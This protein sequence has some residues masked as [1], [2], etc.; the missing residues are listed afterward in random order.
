MKTEDIVIL[1]TKVNKKLCGCY[2][3]QTARRRVG[4]PVPAYNAQT[5]HV[6]DAAFIPYDFP[7]ASAP[8]ANGITL[9]QDD[10]NRMIGEMSRERTLMAQSLSD[11][12]NTGRNTNGSGS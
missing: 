3:C 1:A 10:V 11:Y 8:N 12:Y 4:N 7:Q 9:T 2:V 6:S 5:V